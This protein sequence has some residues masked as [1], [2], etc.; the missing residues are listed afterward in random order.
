MYLFKLDLYPQ[1]V[2]IIYWDSFFSMLIKI[3]DKN[4][5]DKRRPVFLLEKLNMF[6]FFE[7]R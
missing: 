4:W 3:L 7:S 6:G 2:F 5:L 1:P